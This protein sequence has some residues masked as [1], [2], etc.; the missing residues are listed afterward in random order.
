MHRGKK[1]LLFFILQVNVM[2]RKFSCF[3]HKDNRSEPLDSTHTLNWILSYEGDLLGDGYPWESQTREKT[4]FFT[5]IFLFF[6]MNINGSASQISTYCSI[7]SG[8]RVAGMPPLRP[9][10]ACN[11]Y[12][13]YYEKYVRY[14]TRWISGQRRNWADQRDGMAARDVQRSE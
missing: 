2:R 13:R 7:I 12:S 9:R 8:V 14:L 1:F 3:Y 6:V 10:D 4:S 11:S 5:R